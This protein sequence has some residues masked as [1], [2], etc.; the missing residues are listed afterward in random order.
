MSTHIR[1]QA[2][3][4]ALSESRGHRFGLAEAVEEKKLLFRGYR[5]VAGTDSNSRRTKL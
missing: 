5:V 2:Y 3:C 1:V 4:E